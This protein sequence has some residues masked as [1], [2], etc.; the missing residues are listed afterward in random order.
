MKKKL[1]FMLI[2]AAAT[3][4]AGCKKDDDES[5]K[6]PPYAA[7][8]QTWTFGDQT[9]SDDIQ[10]PECN[11][12]DFPDSDTEPQCRSYTESEKTYYYYNW[13]YVKTNEAKMCPSPWRVPTRDDFNTLVSNMTTYEWSVGGYAAGDNASHPMWMIGETGRYWSSTMDAKGDSN[14]ALDY[15][16][17]GH[18]LYVNTH[19]QEYGIHVRCVK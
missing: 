17:S 19:G 5:A 7:T 2:V 11:K 4:F 14:Y 12:E 16:S 1:F 8:T 9:W 15:Y 3:A 13:A 18:N 6:T 10:C